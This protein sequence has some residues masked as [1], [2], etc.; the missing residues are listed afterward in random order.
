MLLLDTNTCYIMFYLCDVL[1]ELLG[2][3]DQ[4]ITRNRMNCTHIEALVACF[5]V[6]VCLLTLALWKPRQNHNI[7]LITCL[8]TVIHVH[9]CIDFPPIK[10]GT[11]AACMHSD[12]CAF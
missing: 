12:R 6:T 3:I 9:K 11:L 8:V 4:M 7:L 1:S 5:G 10:M 2:E